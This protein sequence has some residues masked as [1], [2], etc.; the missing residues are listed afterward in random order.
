MKIRAASR[1]TEYDERRLNVWL[2][3]PELKKIKAL[4]EC[5]YKLTEDEESRK[6][7]SFLMG[8][9]PVV[10]RSTLIYA[11]KVL[12]KVLSKEA[13]DTSVECASKI[14]AKK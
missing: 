13:K 9:N 7:A 2:D 8:F 14:K 10:E 3:P 1:I 12:A 6:Y 4:A 5:V 11:I